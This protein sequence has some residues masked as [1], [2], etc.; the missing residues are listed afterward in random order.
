MTVD[1]K[2]HDGT[3]KVGEVIRRAGKVGKNK[4]GKYANHWNIK[5]RLS[6]DIEEV[7]MDPSSQ[8]GK[9]HEND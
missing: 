8:S 1:Y 7:V 6:G 4:T 2:A 3:W 5:D 9:E